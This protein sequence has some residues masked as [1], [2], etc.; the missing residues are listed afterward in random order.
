MG[1]RHLVVANRVKDPPELLLQRGQAPAHGDLGVRHVTGDD[2]HVFLEGAVVD[3]VDP[4]FVLAVVE[5]DVRQREDS[6]RVPGPSEVDEEAR[7]EARVRRRRLPQEHLLEARV[8]ALARPSV[9][10]LLE[11][12][13]LRELHIALLVHARAQQ[14]GAQLAARGCQRRLRRNGLA[15][16]VGRG[17]E[18]PEPQRRGRAVREEHGAEQRMLIW[19]LHLGGRVGSRRKPGDRHGVDGQG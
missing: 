4:V 18:G 3:G 9:A 7:L 11:L 14:R 8:A 2:Q 16:V 19:F 5:V 17:V 13:G 10:V 1:D 15:A 6:R 12:Q